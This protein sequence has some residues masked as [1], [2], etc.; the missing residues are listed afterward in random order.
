[1]KNVQIKTNTEKKYAISTDLFGIF[2]EDINFACDGGLNANKVNN[3]SFDGAYRD[4]KTNSEVFDYLRYWI[5]E[6]GQLL[7]ATLDITD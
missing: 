5:V 2:L 6:C 7:S 3:Y 1:M 4:M